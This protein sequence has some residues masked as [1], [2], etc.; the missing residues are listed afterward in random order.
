MKLWKSTTRLDLTKKD[1]EKI[2]AELAQLGVGKGF[3][4]KGSENYPVL[5]ELCYELEE[6]LKP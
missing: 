5:D 2:L 1:M 3:R 6:E 4:G